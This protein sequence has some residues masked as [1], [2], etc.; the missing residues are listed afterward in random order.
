MPLTAPQLEMFLF[1]RGV[2]V[3]CQHSG[4]L[5]HGGF[6]AMMRQE[7]N[8]KWQRVGRHFDTR[9]FGGTYIILGLPVASF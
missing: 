9:F 5:W 7:K 2:G 4:K 6:N 8:I 3:K 1:G